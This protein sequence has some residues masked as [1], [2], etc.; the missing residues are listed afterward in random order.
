MNTVKP[1]RLCPNCAEVHG[2]TPN[3]AGG[4]D[5]KCPYMPAGARL[6]ITFRE[7]KKL[8]AQVVM[9]NRRN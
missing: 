2:V 1:A 9:G 5:S 3:A 6:D 8:I 7:R 4:Y